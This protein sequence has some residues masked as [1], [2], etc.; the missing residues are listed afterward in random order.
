MFFFLTKLFFSSNKKT[1]Y[2]LFQQENIPYSPGSKW[3]IF[4]LTCHRQTF[5]SQDMFNT[6]I[7]KKGS[8]YLACSF[9]CVGIIRLTQ[10]S[11]GF[12]VFFFAFS[13][14]IWKDLLTVNNPFFS[15][16][17]PY[18]FFPTLWRE[19]FFLGKF[20]EKNIYLL[21]NIPHPRGIK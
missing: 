18:S 4:F 15:H 19:E 13:R 6:I 8:Y 17:F 10:R 7:N 12:F 9:Q 11:N 16:T 20:C 21:K 2:Y 3:N 14:G 5:F 1:Y